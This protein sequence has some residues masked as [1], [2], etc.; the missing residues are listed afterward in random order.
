MGRAQDMLLYTYGRRHKRGRASR[1]RQ[2]TDC[3]NIRRARIII[4]SGWWPAGWGAFESNPHATGHIKYDGPGDA[5]SLIP[6]HAELTT[7]Q[8]ADFLNVPRPHLVKLLESGS[9]PEFRQVGRHR[10]VMFKDLLAYQK[11]IEKIQREALD[12][13]SEQAQALNMCY[14]WVRFIDHGESR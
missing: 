8:A 13:L 7:Q 1:C 2:S 12:A 14:W 5:I 10:R 4:F 9:G 3:W 11:R 6:I